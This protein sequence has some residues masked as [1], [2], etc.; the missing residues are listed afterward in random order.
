MKINREHEFLFKSTGAKRYVARKQ[1]Q[2]ANALIPLTY[3]DRPEAGNREHFIYA[4]DRRCLNIT[5]ELATVLNREFP[6]DVLPSGFA[7][8]TAVP[9]DFNKLLNVSGCGAD[10]LPIPVYNNDKF[11]KSLN[12]ASSIRPMDVPWFKELVRLFFGAATPADLHIRIAAS[13][14]FPWFTNDNQ[15]KKLST[16]KCLHNIDDWLSKM[17]GKSADLADALNDYHSIYLYAIQKR[18]QPDSITN[19][20]GVLTPKPRAVP[21]EDQA[22]SGDYEGKQFADKSVHDYQGN[23]IEGHF[24]M[25]QRTVFGMSGVPNYVMTAVM[26]CFREVY[27]NRFSF[28]YKTRD[29]N[30]KER[31]ISKYKF[32]VGSDVKSMDTSVPQWFFNDLYEELSKYWDERLII[33]LKRMMKAPYVVP[34]PWIKTPEDYNPVFGPSPLQAEKFD[35]AVGL[36]SGVFINPDIGKLWMTFVY[37]ILFRD[38]G[39]LTQVSDIESFLQGNN[40]NHALLDMSDDATMLTNSASVRDRLLEAKSPYAVLEPETPV[41]FLGSVFCEVDGVKRSFPNP[42]TYVVNMLAREDSIDRLNPVNYAEGVLA[43]HQQYSRTPIFRDINQITEEI[44]RKH[45]GVN[46]YLM[47]RSM[48]KRQRFN[49]LDALVIANP[50]YLN[51]RVDPATVSKEVLDEIVATIPA[52]DFFDKIRHLFKVPTTQLGELN[53]SRRNEVTA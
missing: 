3:S 23:L 13:T 6:V 33:V 34:S 22:R 20:N 1:V 8:P 37:V 51:Y 49:D 44:I 36:P 25:R 39:A 30:D 19:V 35:A 38:S 42:V 10:P 28:T 27:L 45:T 29:D 15:Y 16:L 18:Q 12:L 31:K 9:S 17:T 21:T 41:L 24:A 46:P 53:G 11:V 14:G 47:A 43:R 26:G 48:A 40:S 50:H 4:D 7:G 32:T 2:K 52:S 5:E